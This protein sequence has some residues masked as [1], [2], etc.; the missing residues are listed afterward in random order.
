MVKVQLPKVEEDIRSNLNVI[1]AKRKDKSLT[2]TLDYLISLD[3]IIQNFPNHYTMEITSDE[4]ERLDVVPE[5]KG[6]LRRF[7]KKEIE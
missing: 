2:D 1:K 5:F 6:F 3:L 7:C 4:I